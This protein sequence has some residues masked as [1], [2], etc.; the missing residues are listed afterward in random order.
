MSMRLPHLE[1]G[2]PKL[3]LAGY[4]KTSESTRDF[5]TPGTYNCIAW[6]A[7][8]IHHGFWWPEPDS[9]WPHWIVKENTVPCF[10]K[11]FRTL[12][13]TLCKDSKKRLL[14]HKVVLYAI[15]IS[16][17]KVAAPSSLSDL[18]DWQPTHMARQLAD[19]LWTSKCGRDEDI[20]HFTLD[21]LESYGSPRRDVNEYGCPVVY[22]ERFVIVTWIVR[23]AQLLFRWYESI[24]D[25]Y[26]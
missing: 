8:D 3:A 22:M 12:G 17:Q 21:A 13:Y 25:S 15:H 20:T 16:R 10:I 19:G 9:Y 23:F 7:Q 6:A 14:F 5:S 24:R 1:R 11:T 26:R 18:V 4:E 2:F